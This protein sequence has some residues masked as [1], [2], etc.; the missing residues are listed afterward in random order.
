MR[1]KIS[2]FYNQTYNTVH[3]T[4]ENVWSNCVLVKLCANR[5]VKLCYFSPCGQTL[6]FKSIFNNF[7]RELKNITAA[8]NTTNSRNSQSRKLSYST[9]KSILLKINHFK[10]FPWA[11]VE[12]IR[13]KL[14]YNSH[15][16]FSREFFSHR[17]NFPPHT[18]H[19]YEVNASVQ[20]CRSTNN[21]MFFFMIT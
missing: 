7:Y 6:F 21:N 3:M 14:W 11:H 1:R 9:I 13:W 10:S 4:I 17:Q 8:I 19:L 18:L 20:T 5:M 12:H 16:W 15:A 2:P